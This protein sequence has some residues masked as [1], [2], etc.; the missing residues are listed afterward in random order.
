MQRAYKSKI[1]D[2]L[3]LQVEQQMK[4]HIETLLQRVED[5]D[6]KYKKE[7]LSLENRI[8]DIIKDKN[9]VEEQLSQKEQEG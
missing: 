6:N 8:N 5:L 3:Q 2:K 9:R 1:T 7:I 4:I